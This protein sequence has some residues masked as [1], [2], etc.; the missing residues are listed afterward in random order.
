MRWKDVVPGLEEAGLDLLDKMLRTIP[1]ERITAEE[2][3]NHKYF[4]DVP[5][6]LKN[7]YKG[8]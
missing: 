2:A 3:L 1:E 5:Q 8:I 4:S 6:V 7:L